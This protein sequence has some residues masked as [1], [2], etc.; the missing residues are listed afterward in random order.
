MTKIITRKDSD[1]QATAGLQEAY[2]DLRS[3]LQVVERGDRAVPSQA[4]AVYNE[5]S[6]H[7]KSV[8]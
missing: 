4:V 2:Q 3:A 1:P 5:S 8:H 7:V 6:L